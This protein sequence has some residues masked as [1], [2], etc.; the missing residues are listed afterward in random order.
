MIYLNGFY[1]ENGES[2]YHKWPVKKNKSQLK[3]ENH[4]LIDYIPSKYIEALSRKLKDN[5]KFFLKNEN[6]KYIFLI[7]LLKRFFKKFKIN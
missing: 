3:L 1:L 7:N 2:K 4:F 6:R 5:G